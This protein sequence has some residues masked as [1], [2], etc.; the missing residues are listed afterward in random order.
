MLKR[1]EAVLVFIDVQG[2]LH[3]I[4][5]AK[6]TLDASLEKVIRCA[7]LLE[8]PI[9]GTEQI[10]DK[11]GP[12]SEPFKSLLSEVPVIGKSAFSC[13]GEMKFMEEF[14]SL[15]KRQAILVGIETH[16]CVYQTALDLLETGIEVF[17]V[18]DAVSSRAPENK[19]LA[20]QAMRAA[21]AQILPTET[22]LFA[23]LRDAADP[24]FKELLQLI[25]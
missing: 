13:C 10:P 20:L 9:V 1:E 5:D 7:Q 8:I 2:K 21:G 18:A 12:T 16:V 15:G 3:E 23:L 19:A 6:K 22:V 4:M 17:V 24:R 11:L 25:K 14:Q